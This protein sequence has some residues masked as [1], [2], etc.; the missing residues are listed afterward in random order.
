M[1]TERR[2]HTKK[3]LWLGLLMP[4]CVACTVAIGG[5]GNSDKSD[6]VVVQPQR[7]DDVLT[8]PNVGFADFHMGWHCESPDRTAEQCADL[9][10]RNWPKNYPATAVTYFRWHWDQLE[11]KRGM[12]DFDYIDQRIQASNLTGQTL[13]F[14][15]MAIR[16]GGAG[17]PRWLR[18][19][20]A[21]VEVD[22]TFWPDYRDPVFQREHRRFV[23]ALAD[24]YDG[25]PAVDHVDIG[26]V[27][28]WGEWN[29]ACLD[30]VKTIIDIYDPADEAERDEIAEGYKQVV[31]DYADAFEET[32][33]V[34]LAVGSDGDPRMADIMGHALERGTGWRVDCW[35]DWGYFSDNWSHHGSLYP[36]FMAKAREV[37]PPFDE[38]W[39]HAPVQLE[40]CGVMQQW[41]D[42]GWTADSP[43]GRVHKTFQ[44]ALD[45]HAAVL[46]AK[47]SAVP[48][49]YLPA[50]EDL[51]RRN[52]Y[53]YV[54]DRFSHPSEVP[55]GSELML[56]STWSN[57]GVTPS[58]T[59]RVLAYRLRGESETRIFESDAD[60]R[61]WL[62]GSWDMEE[63]FR[64]PSDLPAGKYDIEVAILDRAGTNPT[65]EPLPPLEL[66]MKRR[67]GDGWYSLSKIDVESF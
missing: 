8:N 41:K 7:I 18:D 51:L 38:V 61:N 49:E 32:P 26:P 62:P 54:I 37:Y 27:G 47:R 10:D 43:D 12:I 64:V 23:S 58:Y 29:T 24:R 53:R 55:A 21:G 25:H 13:S 66:G 48:D 40:V 59:P 33:L 36:T 5:E 56:R 15:V 44:F 67:G 57:L 19:E 3:F 4:W 50:V 46:N 65:T 34:M 6:P 63:T 39:K 35:G 52:G 45:H 30:S 60:V 16:S 9:R 42:R 28:C 31:T 2:L 22:E 11:P 1:P 14:R 17:I 20:V